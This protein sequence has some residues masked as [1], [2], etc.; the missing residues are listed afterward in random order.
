MG[1]GENGYGYIIN[2]NGTIIA[3][4]DREKVINQF[5]PIEEAKNDKSMES[6]AELIE[7][8]L[9]ERNGTS[10]CYKIREKYCFSCINT[11]IKL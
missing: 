10:T 5:N 7:K 11:R 8:A 4:P 2:G 3:H 1:Y 9:A 6:H